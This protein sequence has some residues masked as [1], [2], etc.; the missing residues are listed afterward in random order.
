MTAK[1]REVGL[2][3]VVNLGKV[4]I[5]VGKLIDAKGCSVLQIPV[6]PSPLM[7]RSEVSYSW[8][9]R[10]KHLPKRKSVLCF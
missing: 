6:V 1:E 7:R 9:G 3:E 5:W 10:G 2:P 8:P 4:N